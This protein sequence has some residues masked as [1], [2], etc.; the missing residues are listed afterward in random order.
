MP[1]VFAHGELRLYLLALLET[2]PKHGYE[3]I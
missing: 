1:P 3:I 2:G